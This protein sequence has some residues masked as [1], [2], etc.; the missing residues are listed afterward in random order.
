MWVKPNHSPPR[1]GNPLPSP[2]PPPP[3]PPPQLPFPSTCSK[4]KG[5]PTSKEGTVPEIRALLHPHSPSP[6]PS[7][8]PIPSPIPI[9]IPMLFHLYSLLGLEV[10]TPTTGCPP[11]KTPPAV[12]LA[13]VG[14]SFRPLTPFWASSRSSSR[15]PLQCRFHDHLFDTCKPGGKVQATAPWVLPL[16]QPWSRR[17]LVTTQ[18]RCLAKPNRGTP[19]YPMASRK[20]KHPAQIPRGR[21][22]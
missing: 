11:L 14:R 2:P 12:A 8:S 21:G 7:P 9:P 13:G 17:L 18:Y 10:S 20:A 16:P 5:R 1:A 22:S 6:S 19:G 3:L 15:C 4:E